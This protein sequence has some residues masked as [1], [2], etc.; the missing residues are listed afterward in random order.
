MKGSKVAILQY[1]K[2]NGGITSV[3]AFEHFGV[4]R[5]AACVFDLRKLGYD[6]VTQDCI[7]KTR[8]NETCR[9][10]RYVFGPNGG[11]INGK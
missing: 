3:E 4:T 9:Y 10:A 6:I 1:I 5:L 7:G 11:T 2:D 8:F